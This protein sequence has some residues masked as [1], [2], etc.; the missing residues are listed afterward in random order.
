MGSPAYI[1]G[2]LFASVAGFL[3]WL[4]YRFLVPMWNLT[5]TPLA[6]QYPAMVNNNPTY[7]N[8]FDGIIVNENIGVQYAFL[9]MMLGITVVYLIILAY[10]EQYTSAVEDAGY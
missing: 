9:I 2:I 7:V 4:G 3:V 5:S 10:R 6:N 1:W 8:A